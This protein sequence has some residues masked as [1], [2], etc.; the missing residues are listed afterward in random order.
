MIYIGCVV[1]I[2][3]TKLVVEAKIKILLEDER[4]PQ[5]EVATVKALESSKFRDQLSNDLHLNGVGTL[6]FK[7]RSFFIVP[8]E[9][10]EQGYRKLMDTV[11]L[12][13]W[14][15]T[16]SNVFETEEV[17]GQ[18]KKGGCLCMSANGDPTVMVDIRCRGSDIPLST[19]SGSKVFISY[20]NIVTVFFFG[21]VFD[22]LTWAVFFFFGFLMSFGMLSQCERYLIIMGK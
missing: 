7:E 19:P 17:K 15:T 8:I 12:P 1:Y 3:A 18:L 11:K 22:C 6:T 2:L 20:T 21:I 4:L 5:G 14:K 13:V 9:S 10:S 16:I